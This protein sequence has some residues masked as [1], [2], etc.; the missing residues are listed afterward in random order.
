METKHT[1]EQGICPKC[2]SHNLEHG[3]AEHIDNGM[4]YPYTCESCNFDGSEWYELTFLGHTRRSD[5][6]RVFLS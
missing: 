4:N 1:I 3:T 6:E 2:G 5:P